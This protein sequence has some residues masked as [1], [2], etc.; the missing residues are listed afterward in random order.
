[1]NGED[2]LSTSER[3]L[4]DTIRSAPVVVLTQPGCPYCA[5]VELLF[6]EL[7]VK[8][9]AV[10]IVSAPRESEL[11]AALGGKV[12]AS[13]VPQV[14]VAGQHLGGHDDL[15]DVIESGRR[16]AATSFG[17]T[18]GEAGALIQDEPDFAAAADK[19]AAQVVQGWPVK[20]DW[21]QRSFC[22]AFMH[23]GNVPDNHAGG[24]VT[25]LGG[26]IVA[27]LVLL[28]TTGLTSKS[29]ISRWIVVLPVLFG[30]FSGLQGVTNT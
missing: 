9:D 22:D 23:G 11:R 20:I 5:R 18:L 15:R 19:V 14:F 21:S 7:D 30:G 13:S 8:P 16:S 2:T 4:D 26:I 6:S 1:M 17:I 28:F 27:A 25:F 3:G 12:G 24:T 29:S 10:R